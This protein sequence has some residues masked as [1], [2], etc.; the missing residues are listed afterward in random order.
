[1]FALS[2][3]VS[4]LIP[5]SRL[6][7]FD[8]GCQVLSWLALQRRRRT[9]NNLNSI[10]GTVNRRGEGVFEVV[11]LSH[12]I[13]GTLTCQDC[14]MFFA[15]WEESLGGT[16]KREKKKNHT[17]Q[18]QKPMSISSK[19]W[20]KEEKR[21]IKQKLFLAHYHFWIHNCLFSNILL[22]RAKCRHRSKL[23]FCILLLFYSEKSKLQSHL[24]VR[25]NR[26]SPK[27]QHEL[28]EHS[29]GK[30]SPIA[31]HKH[32]TTKVGILNK[33]EEVKIYDILLGTAL[34]YCDH[35]FWSQW[36]W[37]LSLSPTSYW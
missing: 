35:R 15:G 12:C 31:N 37:S 4:H 17:Q 19:V 16:F 26:I 33:R 20:R 7:P 13:Q 30:Y 32:S 28:L 14:L 9:E 24:P 21:D 23:G 18:Q 25:E 11:W 2:P 8:A 5:D 22:N 3:L 10:S 1:M 36:E 34:R 29:G 6:P 27:S